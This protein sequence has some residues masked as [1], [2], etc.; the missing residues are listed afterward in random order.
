V[1]SRTFLR[2]LILVS[3]LATAC[4]HT[5]PT[6]ATTVDPL[7]PRVALGPYESTLADPDAESARLLGIVAW[8]NE[9][10]VA[11]ASLRDLGDA[12][13]ATEEPGT[14]AARS[15]FRLHRVDLGLAILDQD[16]AARELA[17]TRFRRSVP[18]LLRHASLVGDLALVAA[19]IDLDPEAV[20]AHRA[21][22]ATVFE[23]VAPYVWRPTFERLIAPLYA[24]ASPAQRARLGSIGLV[25]DDAVWSAEALQSLGRA[26]TPLVFEQARLALWDGDLGRARALFDAVRARDPHH[27][28][29]RVYALLLRDSAQAEA[30]RLLLRG[31]ANAVRSHRA[32]GVEL[33]LRT[34]ASDAYRLFAAHVLHEG[35]A[36][37]D[38]VARA[39]PLTTSDDADVRA[40][41]QAI[42]E[43]SGTWESRRALFTRLLATDDGCASPDLVR[44]V[45]DSDLD[46]AESLVRSARICLVRHDALLAPVGRRAE[47]V[48]PRG[49]GAR[50]I[51][52]YAALAADPEVDGALRER[53]RARLPLDLR[54]RADWKL[55]CTR[56]LTAIC[57]YAADDR[58]SLTRYEFAAIDSVGA[59]RSLA[60]FALRTDV[61][62]ALETLAA[63]PMRLG[64]DVDAY[65]VASARTAEIA[66][67]SFV[68][69][70]LRMLLAGARTDEARALLAQVAPVLPRSERLVFG[71]WLTE[72]AN[73]P[74]LEISTEF[75]QDRFY[76]N[77]L[78][79][80]GY[81]TSPACDFD[82]DD[83][84]APSIE[85]TD[86]ERASPF[87]AWF[88]GYQML[89]GGSAAGAIPRLRLVADAA[90]GDE[91]VEVL[92]VLAVA[93]HV[94]RDEAARDE[95]IARLHA[96][97]PE[98]PY[99]AL[100]RVLTADDADAAAVV[101]NAMRKEPQ[102]PL[103]DTLAATRRSRGAAALAPDAIDAGVRVDDDYR[104][105]IC[106]AVRGGCQPEGQADP[107]I[108]PAFEQELGAVRAARSASPGASD[109]RAACLSEAHSVL[110]GAMSF[111]GGSHDDGAGPELPT[112]AEAMTIVRA[113]TALGPDVDERVRLEAIAQTLLNAE[114]GAIDRRS[115]PLLESFVA[116]STRTDALRTDPLLA[117]AR[118]RV[119]E[120]LGRREDEARAS[121]MS[122][123]MTAPGTWVPVG[124]AARMRLE[125]GVHSILVGR[126]ATD[127]ASGATQAFSNALGVALLEERFDV[128]TAYLDAL[129]ERVE[130]LPADYE[131]RSHDGGFDFAELAV[132]DAA[133]GTLVVD[134]RRRLIRESVAPDVRV[135]D[136]DGAIAE[137]TRIRAIESLLVR[138]PRSALAL[139]LAL[140]ADPSVQRA[141]ALVARAPT[142]V[143][144]VA[145]AAGILAMRGASDEAAAALAPLIAAHPRRTRLTVLLARCGVGEDEGEFEDEFEGMPEEGDEM[146]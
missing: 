6:S 40:V 110:V 23:V 142:S 113:C 21:D 36:F 71:L 94:V 123:A 96:L 59:R 128:A 88:T 76:P 38:A 54:V 114:D 31:L 63:A 52:T 117:S 48:E 120:W 70:R 12:A 56:G 126:H 116:A 107:F 9:H 45:F 133:E 145:S 50:L 144:A 127:D 14:L 8:E 105:A 34:H 1:T 43:Q 4:A 10:F 136:A 139:Y 81:A 66:M 119:A 65:F 93:L 111:G 5:L 98:G 112:F 17:T 82:P 141:R 131:T 103:V 3:T 77:V 115:R 16:A 47:Y 61:P 58:Y 108:S 30:D 91:L 80:F 134:D 95:V 13:R 84:D 18:A 138:S 33:A 37:P 60:L 83:D 74:D 35:L 68:S 62:L 67:P 124:L 97:A 121:L 7:A 100:L 90:S 22:V 135:I 75:V 41:A 132:L 20:A 24:F 140:H 49:L 87:T 57:P 89:T 19:M 92:G 85:L 102:A 44:R 39:L 11:A 42:V 26:E 27:L 106:E 101:A 104:T 125:L 64:G 73:H 55:A 72:I 129:V 29:A 99:D 28:G 143:A 69:P 46:E 51:E 78:G 146:P 109:P 79:A 2:P 122:V 25:P 15:L 130:R 137:V 86:D 32:A 118:A 53:A